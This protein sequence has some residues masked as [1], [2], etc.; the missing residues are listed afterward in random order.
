MPY[1]KIEDGIFRNPKVV[2][3]SSQAKLM[4]VAS[5]CYAG[6][7]LTDGFVPSN[8]ARMLAAEVGI[9]YSP[10][11]AR[12]LV[13]AGLWDET[14]GGYQIHDY[15]EHNTSS[16]QVRA[17]RD[18]AK[19]RMQ[20][21]RSQYVRANNERSSREVREPET[22]TETE[23]S[24]NG[25]LTP[26]NPHDETG[27]NA[28]GRVD[29][30][31]KYTQDFE[32]FWKA[33]PSGHGVKKKAFGQWKRIR[34]DERQAVM[35]GLEAWKACDRWQRGFVKEAQTWLEGRQWEDDPPAA[36]QDMSIRMMQGGDAR[37]N[38]NKRGG[39]TPGELRQ[40]AQEERLRETSWNHRC[41]LSTQ[42]PRH[43]RLRD[44]R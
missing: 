21:S 5:I 11:T 19:E 18:A 38:P 16:Q 35:D 4:Y 31:P 44:H 32:T 7:S 39:Y 36:A 27:A 25:D 34:A 29:S 40:L 17:K 22:E 28:P 26:P 14:D 41:A 12:E 42:I 3:V 1:V 23:T 33:Y 10:K 13:S 6:S 43:A 20:R 8:V 24:P 15:L 30:S 9:G 2:Q 37:P